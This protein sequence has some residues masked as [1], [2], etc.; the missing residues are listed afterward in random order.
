[1]A[2]NA[3]AQSADQGVPA[4]GW[5][6]LAMGFRPFFLLA[7]LH[8]IVATPLWLLV[9]RGQ[10]QP[11]LAAVVWHGH[12]M[13]YGFAVAVIAGFLLTAVR[14]WTGGRPTASGWSLALLVVLWLL[15]RV[16]WWP[17]A[18]LPPT[19]AALVALAFLPALALAVGR[20]IV[21]ARSARN[22]KVLALIGALWLLQATTLGTALHPSIRES[23]SVDLLRGAVLLVVVLCLVITGRIVPLF[24]RNATGVSEL[25]AWPAA[26]AAT[27]ATVLAVLVAESLSLSHPALAA[28]SI[29]AAGATLARMRWWGTQH[30]LREPLLWILH[31]GHVW[32]AIGLLL[33]GLAQ[34]GV[35]GAHSAFTHALAFGAIGT[36]IL[37]MMARVTLGHTG[38]PLR[39]P[40][41]TTLAFV[42]LTLGTVVRVCVPVLAPNLLLR[43]LD[44]AG[45]LWATAFALFLVA[46]APMLWRP[47]PDGKPG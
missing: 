42:L 47:R 21:A 4:P 46:Q 18:G 26:D 1:M 25:R 13:V 39:A 44:V 16:V 34:L 5:V 20:P 14:H 24:T 10:A 27:F 2:T 31:L 36:L 23:V 11:P 22:Y 7:A 19:L 38:R 12:E 40:P 30:T 9:L 32:I 33:G 43:G 15:G 45:L 35:A 29:V 17:G 6:F 41:L 37:G 8:A 28:L 3:F